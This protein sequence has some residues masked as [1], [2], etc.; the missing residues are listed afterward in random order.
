MMDSRFHPHNTDTILPV[1][2]TGVV[3]VPSGCVLFPGFCD[4]HVHF[5]EPGFSYKETI[6]TGSA[7]AARGGYTTVCTMPNLDPVPD[8]LGNLKM[9]LDIIDRDSLIN[10]Y[11][12]ASITVG[13]KG[14]TLTPMEEICLKY[15]DR[16][17]GF[18]DDGKG[19]ASDAVM[20]EAMIRA[21]ALG[22][23]I[24]AH[25]EDV[26][27][28]RGGYINDGRYAAAHGIIGI[29]SESEWRQIARDLE[30]AAQTGCRY[31]VCHISCRESVALIREAKASGIDVSCE[32]APHY[33]LFDE[34]CLCDDGR[35]RMNPPLRSPYDRD[36]L[37]EGIKDGTIDMIAT[38]HA[39]HSAE[40]KSGGLKNSAFGIVGIETAFPALYTKLVLEGVITFEKLT[41]LLCRNPRKRFGF[42]QND[43]WS[44]WDLEREFTVDPANFLSKGR[45]TPF[46]GM[47][48]RGV[49]IQTVCGGKTVYQIE[50]GDT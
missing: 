4:V 18:S 47:K 26:G 20:R 30:L 39:P 3:P 15:G 29:P 23:I 22:K 16:I 34:D 37:V 41:D 25:C 38:D 42:P 44:A 12:F 14:E 45:S 6:S 8:S 10:I 19:V 17:A 1:A 48:L 40:E 33:L 28:T 24:S 49:C 50:D 11:P 21:A 36:A 5:R 7:A 9:Q 13:E 43:G 32:T 2:E 46:E 35:F 31:H 27:L